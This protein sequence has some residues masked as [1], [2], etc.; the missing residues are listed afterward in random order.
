M[1]EAKRRPGGKAYSREFG[2]KTVTERGF[3]EAGTAWFIPGPLY[4]EYAQR[5]NLSRKYFVRPAAKVLE[6]ET[7]R[8]SSPYLIRSNVAVPWRISQLTRFIAS[9][10]KFS[11]PSEPG[12]Y[13][14]LCKEHAA[15]S[16]EWFDVHGFEFVRE[17]LIPIA[18]GAQF[19]PVEPETPFIYI[20]KFLA[21]LTRYRPRQQLTLALPAFAE[22]NQELWRRVAKSHDVRYGETIT[23]VTRDDVVRVETQTGVHEFDRLVWT[24]PVE[25]FLEVADASDEETSIFSRVKTIDRAVVTCKVDGLAADAFYFV[26]ET[27]NRQVAAT[28]PHVFFAI[29]STSRVYN[30]YPYMS[31]STPL[32]ELENQIE[33]LVGRLGGHNIQRVESP[34]YW[35]WFPHFDAEDIRGGI[36]ERIEE[37]QGKRNTFFAGELIAGVA[38]TYAMEYAA[39]LVHDLM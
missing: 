23:T 17:S 10:Y 35:R 13:H 37:M 12:F 1:L 7:G 29:D 9:L 19:G 28:Y 38:I 5:F 36:Y 30:F 2:E 22:G 8:I 6:L 27:L 26:K 4:F 14:Q 21:L 15:P 33:D 11:R 39:H 24:A 25:G 18:N 16:R 32:A 20:A 3:Y 34:I 31:E